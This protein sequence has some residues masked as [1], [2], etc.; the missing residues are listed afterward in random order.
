MK[1]VYENHSILSLKWA[2]RELS[3]QTDF[4]KM[5]RAGNMRATHNKIYSYGDHF[6]IAEFRDGVVLLTEKRFSIS[7]AKHIN[8][9]G[10]ALTYTTH[11]VI[12]V[13]TL[14][15]ADATPK[16][17]IEIKLKEAS[18]SYSLAKKARSAKLQ[19]I[20]ECIENLNQAAKYAEVFGENPPSSKAVPSDLFDLLAVEVFKAKCSDAWYSSLTPTLHPCYRQTLSTPT[21]VAA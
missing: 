2:R 3:K 7:T 13:P 10:N 16:T 6:C 21:A 4:W 9:V 5:F 11:D 14:D 12:N 17:W 20:C 19:R 18:V 8:L 1:T 15:G